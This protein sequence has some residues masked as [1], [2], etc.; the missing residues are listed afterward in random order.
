MSQPLVSVIIPTYNRAH[1]IIETLKSIQ[2]QNYI[3]WE[4]IIVDDGSIDNSEKVINDFVKSDKR[5]K[6]FKRP[7]VIKRGPS[8]CRN[9]GFAKSNG[10]LITWFD[11]DDIMLEEALSRRVEV[12]QNNIDCVVCQLEHFD[13]K[14]KCSKAITTIHSRS[15]ISDYLIGKVIFFVSGAIWRR[16]FLT[17]Q[18]FLFDDKI[19]HLD[20]WD[21]NLRMLYANPK[22]LF[23]ETPLI[24]YRIHQNSLS[25]RKA[26]FATV[27]IKSEYRARFKHLKLLNNID[28]TLFQDFRIH[29]QGL[30]SNQLLYQL[31]NQKS[32]KLL[33]FELNL[34]LNLYLKDY[35]TLLTQTL[36]FLSYLI[37]KRGYFFF[38]NTPK[39]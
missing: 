7:D 27:R 9:F 21:F 3:N 37:L 4:C 17:K 32:N 16:S 24:R 12:F 10:E 39:R 1:I 11:D 23:V 29:C 5:Y 26:D 34:K 28:K 13:F 2:C 14:Q 8:S 35:S 30:L 15:L 36:G 19:L 20:D 22:V 6:Y 31:E 18:K 25:L 33:M 38:S